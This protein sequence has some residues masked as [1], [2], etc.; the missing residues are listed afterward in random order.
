MHRP[1]TGQWKD[2]EDIFPKGV[3]FVV[4]APT[5]FGGKFEIR[6]EDHTNKGCAILHDILTRLRGGKSLSP[7]GVAVATVD[8][9]EQGVQFLPVQQV[10]GTWRAAQN[11]EG[12]PRPNN[13]KQSKHICQ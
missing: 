9:L 3:I 4:F 5:G 13:R 7:R 1:A 2:L 11:A 6:P 12:Q 8:L 10:M